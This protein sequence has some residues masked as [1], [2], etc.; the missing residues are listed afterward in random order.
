[1]TVNAPVTP[2]VDGVVV[3]EV[4]AVVPGEVGVVELL[5]DELTRPVT[6]SNTTG[7]KAK[8]LRNIHFS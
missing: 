5:H 7:H 8:D 1:V 4:D 6:E 3:A 2:G